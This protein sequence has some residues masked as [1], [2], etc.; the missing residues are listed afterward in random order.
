MGHEGRHDRR[1]AEEH[2]E[3][4]AAGHITSRLSLVMISTM[5]TMDHDTA[6]PTLCC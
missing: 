3:N 1:D 4:G 6:T 5:P 2:P